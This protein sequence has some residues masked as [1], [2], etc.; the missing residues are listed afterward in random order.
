M[1][2]VLGIGLYP[3]EDRPDY[4]ADHEEI[5]DDLQKGCDDHVV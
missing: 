3:A 4:Q 5:E 2:A 1:D